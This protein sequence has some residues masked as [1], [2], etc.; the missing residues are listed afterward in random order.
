[1]DAA[2]IG[3][4]G[5]GAAAIIAAIGAVIKIVLTRP[6]LPVAEELLERMSEIESELLAWAGWGHT[7]RMLAAGQ[8]IDLPPIPGKLAASGRRAEDHPDQP[9]RRPPRDAPRRRYSD[10]PHDERDGDYG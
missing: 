2:T 7:V 5:T 10:G 8:G 9:H 6:R 1:M 3:A 4:L